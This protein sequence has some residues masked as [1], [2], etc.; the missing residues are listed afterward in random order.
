MPLFLSQCT[1]EISICGPRFN[2][3][4]LHRWDL[5]NNIG[6]E[7]KLNRTKT[8][9]NGGFNPFSFS[10]TFENPIRA[11]GGKTGETSKDAAISITMHM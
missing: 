11:V 6:G 2:S 5:Q 9:P 1:R 4:H 3:A 8:V 7:R 10:L